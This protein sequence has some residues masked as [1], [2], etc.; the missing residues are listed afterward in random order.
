VPQATRRQR[1]G[2]FSAQAKTGAPQQT[3]SKQAVAAKPSTY[4]PQRPD[5]PHASEAPDKQHGTARANEG[6]K[7]REEELDAERPFEAEHGFAGALFGEALQNS[8]GENVANDLLVKLG[9][10]VPP[11]PPNASFRAGQKCE[12][13]GT[14]MRTGESL[15][16]SKIMRLEPGTRVEVLE[17]GT[18][19]TG[20]R[21]RVV[22][23]MGMA[24]WISVISAEGVSLLTP[25]QEEGA[26]GFIGDLIGS[27]ATEEED[28]PA[29]KKREEASPATE[30]LDAMMARLDT[31][32]A[33]PASGASSAKPKR[34]SAFD[35]Y[36]K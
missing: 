4:T 31:E 5:L 32:A 10:A 22:T 20:K 7:D 23:P 19:P 21:I 11:P 17:I 6:A 34:K 8:L 35:R 9:K 33:G 15:D 16:S 12:V 2:G 13:I 27:L 24:G 14:I 28:L 30:S 36:V 3:V 29:G 18:G 26:A 25:V 1:A